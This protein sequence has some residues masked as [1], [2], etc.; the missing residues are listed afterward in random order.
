M[1]T[2]A[3]GLLVAVPLPG[4][5][6]ATS[7]PGSAAAA[8]P[9]SAAPASPAS[10]AR[11][12]PELAK[13]AADG[14]LEV[15]VGFD[16]PVSRSLLTD[17]E[18]ASEAER[19]RAGQAA[20]RNL[21]RVKGEVARAVPAA[22]VQHDFSNLPVQ[23]VRVDSAE[24]MRKLAEAPGVI[25]VEVPQTWYLH[26]TGSATGS[27]ATSASA[28]RAP[29]NL[30]LNAAAVPANP[31]LRLIDQPAAVAAG[32][33]GRGTHVAVID[34]GVRTDATVTPY[35]GDC[36]GGF[37]VRDC[38]IDTFTNLSGS[39]LQESDPHG[40]NVAG[41]VAAVAPAAHLDVFNVFQRTPAGL[42]TSD[43][44]V[45]RALDAV[46]S[47]APTR[48]TKAVNLSLGGTDRLYT[49]VCD[50]SY[51]RT[52]MQLRAAGVMPVVAS[53]NTAYQGGAFRDG[54]MNPACAL[55]AVSVGAVYHQSVG[56][57]S[58]FSD[59]SICTDSTTRA[60]LVACFS[61]TGPTLSLLAPGT[62]ISIAG[63][64][65]S[66][67]SQAAP[68]VSGA[69]AAAASAARSTT[70]DQ[71]FTALTSNGP[72]VSDPRVPG[73]STHRLDLAAVAQ[74]LAP[75]PQAQASVGSMLTQGQQLGE[76]Q[77]LVSPGGQHQLAVGVV[78]FDEALRLA[79]PSCLLTP[80][81]WVNG[82]HDNTLVMQTDGN[83]VLYSDGVATWSS[84]TVGNPGARVMLQDDRNVVI[85]SASDAVLWASGTAC[86]ALTSFEDHSRLVQNQYLYPGHYVSSPDRRFR[87][88]LQSDGNLVLYGP[89]AALWST[90]TYGNPGSV[91]AMQF[92]GNLVLY[93]PD[94]RALWTSGTFGRG[95]GVRLIPQNDGN[96]VVYRSGTPVWAT[97]TSVR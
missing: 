22:V 28:N 42:T 29:A 85:Y 59:M 18:G 7:S 88:T 49:Q 8:S 56:S 90:G 40:T 75:A 16:A 80:L 21:D 66:G 95:V 92:D 35:F 51:G 82:E 50:S 57:Q 23:L 13:L 72:L 47:A 43:I 93:A 12:S 67:T 81:A 2:L 76:Q 31:W 60:D 15:L 91:L 14:P 3:A 87:L 30:A 62:G 77:R 61:A 65:M 64:E 10:Q 19:A 53:G 48:D 27:A 70:A 58:Y 89:G 71:L 26:S 1:L 45:L 25:S 73:R 38:R 9:G 96:L 78:G 46:M 34:A 39:G 63:I 24:T 94:G 55:G 54:I 33:D 20:R 5:P 6:A 32:Y 69:I 83:L 74:S 52:F 79:G 68:M 84:G 86:T 4:A 17:A 11:V 36:T 44:T 41:I 37:G 97:R